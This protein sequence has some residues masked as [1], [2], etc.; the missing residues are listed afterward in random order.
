[1]I[2]K[3][4]EE[5]QNHIFKKLKNKKNIYYFNKDYKF[6][7]THKEKFYYKFKN[8]EKIFKKPSLE[9]KHQIENTSSAVTA[10]IILKENNYSIKLNSMEKSILTTKW[11]GRIEKL[12]YKNKIIILDGSHNLSGAEKLNDYLVANKIKPLTVFGMLNNKDVLGFLQIL[13]NNIDTLYPIQIPDE[14]NAL[15]KNEIFKVAK[16]LNIKSL[17]KYNLK[18]INQS[19]MKTCN[20]YILITG[21]LYLVGKIRKKYL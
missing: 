8:F 18:G 2:A 21:S 1:M 7:I 12:I 16:K 10:A 13:K 11:P 3:Q 9:G 4:K 19:L 15:T 14:K 5:V 17:L 6:K 20:K